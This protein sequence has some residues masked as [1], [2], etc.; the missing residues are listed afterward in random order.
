MFKYLVVKCTQLLD[1]FECDADREILCMT[2]DITNY[3]NQFGYEV[4]QVEEDGGLK[5]IKGW[6]DGHQ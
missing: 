6:Q 2:N 1:D 3:Y 5:L 4:Y